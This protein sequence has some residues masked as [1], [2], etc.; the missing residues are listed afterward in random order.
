L[1]QAPTKAYKKKR[2]M[3]PAMGRELSKYGP[4]VL[5][6]SG[7]VCRCVLQR[8]TGAAL[9]LERHRMLVEIFPAPHVWN[10]LEALQKG[11]TAMA[12]VGRG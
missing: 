2:K 10:I 1:L 7:W 8:Q 4:N 5:T 6:M 3:A 9:R 11:E 12:Q